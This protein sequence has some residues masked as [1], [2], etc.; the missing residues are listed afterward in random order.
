MRLGESNDV[1][2]WVDVQ[3]EV[4]FNDVRIFEI[5]VGLGVS[6]GV[7]RTA[8]RGR[9]NRLAGCRLTALGLA[10]IR[11][12]CRVSSDILGIKFIL[13]A[14]AV[15]YFVSSCSLGETATHQTP[16]LCS[17]ADPAQSFDLSDWFDLMPIQR[18]DIPEPS[19]R[20][21]LEMQRYQREYQRLQIL[22]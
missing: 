5:N 21:Y 8:A 4:C 19:C 11:L 18:K 15:L 20:P 3:I 1:T 22:D 16:T 13:L 10:P 14:T 17:S 7:R 12:A 6:R 9:F 2:Q